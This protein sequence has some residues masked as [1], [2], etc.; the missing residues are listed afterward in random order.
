M[1][2]EKIDP[3]TPVSEEIEHPTVRA[4]RAIKELHL[5]H[6]AKMDAGFEFK[7]SGREVAPGIF[8][9]V[10]CNDE[11]RTACLEQIELCDKI[12]ETA[13][14]LPK[15]MLR[16]VEFLLHDA[17]EHID[18]AL[19]AA[20]ATSTEEPLPEIGNYDHKTG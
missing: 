8:E 10:N 19:A 12:M 4:A 16:P 7:K 20:T 13:A 15:D 3:P 2:I 5:E 6:I 18:R 14:Q 9:A 11:M 1:S 17:R